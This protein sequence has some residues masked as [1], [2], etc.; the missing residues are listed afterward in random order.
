MVYSLNAEY[1]QE[2]E[3]EEGR[4][5]INIEYLSRVEDGKTFKN[6]TTGEWYKKS[7]AV[8]YVDDENNSLKF[9]VIATDIT[10]SRYNQEIDFILICD[11]NFS[12]KYDIKNFF[13]TMKGQ[14][15]ENVSK[16]H[17]DFNTA[18]LKEENV[19]IWPTE[20]RVDGSKG[21]VESYLGFDI[22]KNDFSVEVGV[23]WNI[24][25]SNWNNSYTVRFQSVVEGL[26]KDVKTTID[27]NLVKE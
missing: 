11:G 8:T 1:V 10:S 22:E 15:G 25:R 26:S 12:D 18:S 2:I 16:N 27:V 4:G 20:E 17:L 21:T 7:T 19:E 9:Q 14:D 3:V 24:P 23:S 13:F 6:H 5:E